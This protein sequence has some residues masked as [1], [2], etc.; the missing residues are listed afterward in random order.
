[1]HSNLGTRFSNSVLGLVKSVLDLTMPLNNGAGP[2][3]F[4]NLNWKLLNAHEQLST[5]A[6]QPGQVRRGR[7]DAPTGIKDVPEGAGPGAPVDAEQHEQ[8]SDSARHARQVH[9][10]RRD[11]STGAGAEGEGARPGAPVDTVQHEQPSR[12]AA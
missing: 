1:V 7:G 4:R 9:R 2:D 8:P 3:K 12:S 11:V 6:G 10:G 5:G